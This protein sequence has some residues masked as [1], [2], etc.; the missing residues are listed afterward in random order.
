MKVKEPGARN[1]RLPSKV[2]YLF[3]LAAK[4]IPGEEVKPDIYPDVRWISVTDRSREMGDLAEN[5]T[6]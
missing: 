6:K 4:G 5:D 1:T 3:D 2:P